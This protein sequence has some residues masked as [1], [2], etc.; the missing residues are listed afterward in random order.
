MNI[1]NFSPISRIVFSAVACFLPSHT[2]QRQERQDGY[3]SFPSQVNNKMDGMGFDIFAFLYKL[4]NKTL[5]GIGIF[6][7][8]ESGQ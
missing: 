6:I 8:L 1:M 5:K 3:S 4:N 2:R 7:F